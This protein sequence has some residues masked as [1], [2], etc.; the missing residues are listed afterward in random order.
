MNAVRA[1]IPILFIFLIIWG[2]FYIIQSKNKNQLTQKHKK[3]RLYLSNKRIFWIVTGYILI[4]ILAAGFYAFIPQKLTPVNVYIDDEE[5]DKISNHLYDAINTGNIEQIDPSF[6]S[7]KWEKE[8]SGKQLKIVAPEP[9]D[10][11]PTIVVERKATDDKLIEGIYYK[12]KSYV[13]GIDVTKKISSD[14]LKW[15]NDTLTLIEPRPVKLNFAL[16]HK[17]ITL[18]QFTEE[19]SVREDDFSS[20]FGINILY[21]RVPKDLK[22]IESEEIGIQYVGDSN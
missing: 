14:Q 19:P 8:Y 1:I 9:N 13:D 20:S 18:K 5:Y 12:T 15:S 7:S 22:I 21:L 4:L 11:T 2:I 3:Q 10:I 6:I 17:D 16:F